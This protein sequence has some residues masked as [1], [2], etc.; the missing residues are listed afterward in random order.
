MADKPTMAGEYFNWLYDQVYSVRDI[1]SPNSYT[2]LCFQMDEI[3]FNH[4]VPNDVNRADDAVQ[5]RFEFRENLIRHRR[6]FSFEPWEWDK[7]IDAPP[8]VFEVLVALAGRA[9][10][11]D[12]RQASDWFAEFVANLKLGGYTDE[13]YEES[14]R[15]RVRRILVKFNERRYDMYGRGG[16]F[17]L[18]EPQEDQRDVELWYQ[19]AA[20][21]IE[22][23]MYLWMK[24][25]K[26]QITAIGK[27]TTSMW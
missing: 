6:I 11:E 1:D 19:K 26:S 3:A 20:Y 12:G 17:P 5:F 21:M 14:D 24:W 25:K 23:G 27:P 7:L 16:I 2:A 15:S 4:S 13:A 10:F 9:A 8:S 22:N 18:R